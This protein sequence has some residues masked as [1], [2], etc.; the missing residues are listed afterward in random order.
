MDQQEWLERYTK[1]FMERANLGRE[2]A[3]DC[4]DAVDFADASDGFEDDPEGAAEEEM[5]YWT[6]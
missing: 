4:R 1:R 5:S 3:E 2:Q 6:E